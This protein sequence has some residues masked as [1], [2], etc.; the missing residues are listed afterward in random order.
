MTLPVILHECETWSL[1]LLDEH[2]LRMCGNRVL[3]T[4]YGCKRDNISEEWR[5]LHRQEHYDPN[6]STNIIPVIN[7]RSIR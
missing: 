4:L 2:R 6:C 7:W 5:R 3:Q 1:K